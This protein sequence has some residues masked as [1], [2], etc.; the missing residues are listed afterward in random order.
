[1]KRNPFLCIAGC[2]LVAVVA[3]TSLLGGTLAK[4]TVAATS[5][6]NDVV[7]KF[8]F[9]VESEKPA[10]AK[11]GPFTSAR[12]NKEEQ[13][14]IGTVASFEVPMF[15]WEYRGYD[16]TAGNITVRGMNKDIVIAPG[17]GGHAGE[18]VN[19]PNAIWIAGHSNAVR[20][21]FKNESGVAV[22]F[23]LTVN[24][25]ASSFGGLP[26]DDTVPIAIFDPHEE[27]FIGNTFDMNALWV[28][29][30]DGPVL[31][32]NDAD[33]LNTPGAVLEYSGLDAFFT[34]LGETGGW[35][36]MGGRDDADAYWMT[37]KPEQEY[38]TGFSWLWYVDGPENYMTHFHED[39]INITHIEVP[40]GSGNYVAVNNRNNINERDTALGKAAADYLK[41]VADGV[42][43]APLQAALDACTVKLVFKLEV[44]QVN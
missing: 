22:K 11:A 23:R 28:P 43:G 12:G 13:I 9:V 38:V 21:A 5:S 20:M 10:T 27:H 26:L 24:K 19:N 16:S 2:L 34:Q 3:S 40:P 6:V 15:D 39:Y 1:M 44:L 36:G 25:A 8:S 37:L 18:M 30:S 17:S 29:L 31:T 14:A 42:T 33:R 4:Y 35:V 7:V 41:A 32:W